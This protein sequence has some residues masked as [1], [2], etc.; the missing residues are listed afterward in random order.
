MGGNFLVSGGL[1]SSKV[2]FDLKTNLANQDIVD[3]TGV[4]GKVIGKAEFKNKT[5]PMGNQS[6]LTYEFKHSCEWVL[7]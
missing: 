1:L 3:Q 7:L 4:T 6:H 2:G 5:A